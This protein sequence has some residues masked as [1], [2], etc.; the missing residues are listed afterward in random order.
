MATTLDY[1]AVSHEKRRR[2]IWAH[3]VCCQRCGFTDV[4][5]YCSRCG[6]GLHDEDAGV[7]RILWEELVSRTLDDLFA[8]LKTT[9]MLLVHPHRF[10]AAV[11]SRH[12]LADDPFPLTKLWAALTDKP[13]AV[14]NAVKY[15]GILYTVSIVVAWSN[16][17]DAF[18][19]IRFLGKDPLPEHL[20]EALVLFLVVLLVWLYGATVS[21]LMA[22]LVATGLLTKFLLYAMG[23]T[24]IAFVGFVLIDSGHYSVLT[25]CIA[26][27]VYALFIL[28]QIVLPRLYGISHLR[29][30]GA[31]LL[32]ALLNFVAVMLVL[33]CVESGVTRFAGWAADRALEATLASIT[34]GKHHVGPVDRT[35]HKAAEHIRA[36]TGDAIRLPMLPGVLTRAGERIAKLTREKAIVRGIATGN[37]PKHHS[38]GVKPTPAD[39]GHLSPTFA[40]PR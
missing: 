4:G 13:Q 40:S 23:L 30:A 9:W 12:A 3:P 10:F 8:L 18:G 1:V 31:Q 20:A 21:L 16:G 22:H 11:K 32:A 17:N 25:T 19:K 28:P 37:L 36:V 26:I 38:I 15:F 39:G 7:P 6:D 27:M 33:T 35:I 14:H 2:A 5:Q 24:L 34:S 29:L